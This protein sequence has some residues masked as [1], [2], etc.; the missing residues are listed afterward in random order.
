M[1]GSCR[2]TS[3]SPR[4]SST[5]SSASASFWCC[6]C[7]CC[8]AGEVVVL[9]PPAKKRPAKPREPLL[10]LEESLPLLS[11]LASS[12]AAIAGASAAIMPSVT[13][14]WRPTTKAS[15]AR[16]HARRV[17]GRFASSVVSLRAPNSRSSSAVA[18]VEA[19]AWSL[20]IAEVS[21]STTCM[22]GRAV[23][24]VRERAAAGSRRS[25]TSLSNVPPGI[26]VATDAG[27]VSPPLDAIPLEDAAAEDAAAPPEEA[28]R[29]AA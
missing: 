25:T 8:P 26:I 22:S 11:P 19:G 1:A 18:P 9:V 23:R 14:V 16:E 29:A 28:A 6:C 12:D 13:V 27:V 2:K 7:C 20:W 10:P 3:R 21:G 24:I 5:L 17:S 15:E 4:P